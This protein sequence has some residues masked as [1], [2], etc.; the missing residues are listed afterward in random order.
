MSKFFRNLFV[1]LAIFLTVAGIFML[2][3]TD[4]P[5]ANQVS[6]GKVADE[7]NA[8]QVSKIQVGENELTV[9]LKDGSKQ[10]SAKEKEVALSDTLKNTYGVDPAKIKDANIEPISAGSTS[11]LL[12]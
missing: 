10:T 7:I 6:L 1:I 12:S 3:G 4:K 9:F 11:I 8:G 2:F 5:K